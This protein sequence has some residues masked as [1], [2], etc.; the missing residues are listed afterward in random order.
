MTLV[1]YL[2]YLFI[3]LSFSNISPLSNTFSRVE[4]NLFFSG[5]F[6]KIAYFQ[7]YLRTRAAI[8]FVYI[9]KIVQVK[10]KYF[11]NKVTANEITKRSI[12]SGIKPESK[13]CAFA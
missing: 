3:C 1:I 13:L 2:F 10:G 12:S 8:T 6:R 7:C 9:P 11:R 5:Y 4:R